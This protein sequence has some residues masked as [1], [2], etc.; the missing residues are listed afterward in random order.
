MTS[1][2]Q[3]GNDV[4][5]VAGNSSFRILCQ[6]LKGGAGPGQGKGWYWAWVKGV[7]MG[8]R[9]NGDH[10][11]AVSQPWVSGREEHSGLL[12]CFGGGCRW[13]FCFRCFQN[14]SFKRKKNIYLRS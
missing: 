4:N 10:S 9:E 6:R 11:G 2:A 12:V 13:L 14:V 8:V 5:S 3:R 7:K 1:E